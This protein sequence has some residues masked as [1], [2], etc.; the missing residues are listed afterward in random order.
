VFLFWL[1]LPINYHCH[2][3]Y[4]FRLS[5]GKSLIFLAAIVA[6]DGF[7][8]L[9]TV[10]VGISS[11]R[12]S[13]AVVAWCLW[14]LSPLPANYHC[15]ACCFGSAIA[16]DAYRPS[17]SSIDAGSTWPTV[18]PCLLFVS[19]VVFRCSLCCSGTVT[20]YCAKGLMLLG[21]PH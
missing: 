7:R 14:L 10:I 5:S 13:C 17:H 9:P 1:L 21:L 16:V 8:C 15:W 11:S 4:L 6:A 18:D 12:H 3:C 2:H 20:P 19:P